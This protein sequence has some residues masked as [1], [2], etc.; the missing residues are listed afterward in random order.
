[1]VL[2]VCV[3]TSVTC[4]ILAAVD[5]TKCYATGRGI[6]PKGVRIGEDADFC[7]HT[8]GAGEGELVIK[9]V[10]PGGVEERLRIRKVDEFTAE[11]I[12]KPQKPG[13]YVVTIT[14]G[15]QHISKSPFNV[16]V[17]PVKSSK[18]RAYGPGLEGGVVSFPACFIVDTN[19]E[20]GALGEWR[21]REVLNS[22][23]ADV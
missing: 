9:V 17:G 11:C 2:S 14:Y 4:A 19:G 1:M 20:T 12:Y 5:A 8:K 22:L 23:D 16:E 7:V 10:G 18:I 15:G 6:Q 3:P 13:K 21:R